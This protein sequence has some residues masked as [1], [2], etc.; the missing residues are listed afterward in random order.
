MSRGGGG[1]AEGW[2]EQAAGRGGELLM[3]PTSCSGVQT[4]P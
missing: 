1:G 4:G 2:K 3:P